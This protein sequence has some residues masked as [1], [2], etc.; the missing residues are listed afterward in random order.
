M[1]KRSRKELKTLAKRALLGN[2]GTVA[3]SLLLG[4]LAMLAMVIPMV[5]VL[6][7]V[8]FAGMSGG[9]SFAGRYVAMLVGMGIWYILILIVGTLIMMGNTRI[10]YLFCIG[11]QG[12]LGDLLYAFKNRPF[13]F[14]GLSLLI[15]LLTMLGSLPGFI[16]MI[17]GQL[18]VKGGAG[19]L[20]YLAGYVLS[21]LLGITAVLRY[22]MAIFVLLEE[23]DRTVGECIHLSKDMMVGNK[24]RLFKLQVSFI[25]ILMLNYLTFG[26]G[27]LWILP[28]M[29]STN[30]CFYLSVKEEKYSK[31][32]D[33]YENAGNE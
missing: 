23:P 15:M 17:V 32:P 11:Q 30:I 26:L 6:F 24:M 10:C 21:F 31:T 8:M 14:I 1:M 19:I 20:L 2:Y 18:M 33:I 27:M 25:G 7:I 9:A 13:R 4:G 12:K 22:S 29:T 3:G 16:M 28:Y 5:V